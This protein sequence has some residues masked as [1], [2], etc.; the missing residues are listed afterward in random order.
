MVGMWGLYVSIIFGIANDQKPSLLHIAPRICDY[1]DWLLI[2]LVIFCLFKKY[3]LFLHPSQTQCIKIIS[4]L[5]L[6]EVPQCLV[7]NRIIT[8]MQ[9]Y[10]VSRELSLTSS[11]VALCF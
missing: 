9:Y 8:N 7:A 1:A 10:K 3:L 2:L 11:Y 5:Y 6:S 4:I